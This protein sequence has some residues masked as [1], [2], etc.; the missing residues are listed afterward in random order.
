M[1]SWFFYL[2]QGLSRTLPQDRILPWLGMA[3]VL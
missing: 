2:K 3:S 1:N